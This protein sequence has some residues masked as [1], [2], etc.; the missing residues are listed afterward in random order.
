MNVAAVLFDMDGT[1]VDSIPAWHKTFNQSLVSR[2]RNPVSYEYFC[3]E[4]LGEST[5]EDIARFFP[6]LSV[7]ELIGLYDQFFPKNIDAVRLFPET[8]E[9]IDFL[10]SKKI[11]MGLVTNTPRELMEL[12][13]K[14]VGLVDSFDS[15]FGGDDVSVGK[16]DPMMIH[17]CLVDLG[18]D[19]KNAVMV[20]DT[21]SDVKAGLNAG[22]KTIGLGVDADWRIDSIS[23]LLKLLQEI[24]S[25]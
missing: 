13:L 18:V 9:V 15:T 2:G 17:Q 1:L 25:D 12:T 23:E 22:V 24:V 4:I 14:A 21:R 20:G 10:R 11:K 16:P 19:V 8:S 7:S 5:E 3:E 6:D